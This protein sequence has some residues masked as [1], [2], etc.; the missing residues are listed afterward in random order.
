MTDDELDDW[1]H[2]S[3]ILQVDLD[4]SEDLHNLHNDYPLAS[5]RVK[6]G[7]MVKLIPNLDNK[8]NYIVYYE[9]F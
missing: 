5:E 1:K 2:L 9:N 8:T 3:C 4:Y 6:I 7:N